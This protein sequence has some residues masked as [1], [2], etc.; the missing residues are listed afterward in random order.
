[1][2]QRGVTLDEMRIAIRQGWPADD[3]RPGTIGKR[4]VFPYGREWEG[5]TYEEKEITVY[6]KMVETQIIL[7]TVVARYGRDFPRS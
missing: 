7:L 1:M 4:F 2:S 6:Y 5:R 3:A